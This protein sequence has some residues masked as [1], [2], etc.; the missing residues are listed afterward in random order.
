MKKEINYWVEKL[1]LLPHPEGGFYKETYRS[2]V[3]ANFA[4]FDGSRNVVTGIYFLMTK[5]NFS[6]FHR[7]KSDEMWHFYAGDSLEIYWFSPQGEL[8]VISLGLDLEKGEVPQAVVPKDGWF[9]SRVKNGGDYALVGCTVAPGFDF[10]DFELANREDLL[11]LYPRSA[12]I[13]NQLTRQ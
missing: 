11:K 7:I 8:E 5:D 4:G 6:A 2:P 10:Q 3:E 9:A 1:E 13:I 12:E